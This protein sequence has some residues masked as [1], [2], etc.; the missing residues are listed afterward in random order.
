[1]IIPRM[2]KDDILE[3]L[4]SS[5]KIIIIYGARQVGKTT[6]VKDIISA[7]RQ[8]V[9]SV[10]A[11]ELRYH[12]ILSSRDLNKLRSL[13]AGYDVLF[14]D[15]AQRIED[16]GINLKL[17]YDHIPEIKVILT[18]SSSLDLANKTKEALTGRTWTYML[19]PLSLVELS[20]GF[21][22]FELGERLADD[23]IYGHYPELL[24][25]KGSKN[26][27]QYLRELSTAYL[28]KDVLDLVHIKHSRKIRDLL[29][30]LAFHVG[31][32]VSAVELG[33]QLGMAKETV[34]HYVDLLEKAFVVY[35]L[36][37]FSRNLRKEVTKMD[38]IFFVDLGIRN[39]LMDNFN[40]LRFRGDQGQLW[41]NYLLNERRKMLCSQGI[42]A[43]TYFWRTYTGAELDYIEE[44][45]GALCGYEFKYQKKGKIPKGWLET[46]PGA[47][48]KLI[49][50]ENYLD[51]C[52]SLT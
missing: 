20:K 17:I 52:L 31:S 48:A 30:L 45:Q 46:Y 14:L 15:E 22:R 33:A 10:N 19:Y 43:N 24:S 18:G 1:M 6:M 25:I 34:D 40:P 3:K 47:S 32:Q 39:S 35:R 4:A 28:Y 49:N 21:N 5:R 23:L 13:L 36:S 12:D 51:F 38:K 27:E 41:E 16:I 2:Y 8:R 11:D 50:Q 9:L 42:S 7:L 26:K 44:A 29:R 37:G